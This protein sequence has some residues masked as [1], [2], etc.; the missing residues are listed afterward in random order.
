MGVVAVAEVLLGDVIG[1]TDALGDVLAGHLHVNTPGE[2][3]LGP[4]HGKELAH[5]GEDA[6][7][8][9]GLDPVRTLYRIGVHGIA[10]PDHLAALALDRADER[11]QPAFHLVDTHAHD[12]RQPARLVRG[13]EGVDEAEQVIG[14]HGRSGL[15]RHRIADTAHEF[16]V[17]TVQLPRA[18][19]DPHQM[20]RGVV[21]VAGGAVDAG[22][23]FLV[24][25]QQAL[26]RGEEVGLADLRRGFRGQPAGGHEG[27][28]LVEPVGEI[29][30]AFGLGAVG[31]E[32]VVPLVNLVQ[33]GVTALG[34]GAQKIE[35]RRGLIVGL[36]QALRVGPAGLGGEFHAVD[37]VAAV[38]G[39]GDRIPGLRIR[40]A[41][42]CEL[43]GQA[44]HL[45][46]R[47]GAAVGEH[48]RHLQQNPEG[49]P[50][51]VG[52]ELGEALGAVT[53]LQEKRLPRRHLGQGR[54]Q[55]ARLAGE[56]QRREVP[57]TRFHGSHFL[58]IRILRN[59]PDGFGAPTV[60]RPI[61][62][63]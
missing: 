47:T 52:M 49:V 35:G 8:M 15:H 54:L 21:P 61:L 25:K 3:A 29:A 60:R 23:G 40:A 4:V 48:H 6:V 18:L 39:Q 34:E 31:N 24:R 50:D 16:H 42:F 51:I 10:G 7:E 46:H 19:A 45:D 1:A 17:G 58:G 59:L 44:P 32:I 27:Q 56:D 36:D 22:H 26:V 5:L 53:A 20:R 43:A 63:H 33:I 57:Q 12:H 9:T 14:L 55:A 11:R 37:H 28:R 13:I 38:A 2:R 62:G 41:G 30:V